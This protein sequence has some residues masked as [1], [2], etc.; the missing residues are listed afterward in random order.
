MFLPMYLAKS[1]MVPLKCPNC[2]STEPTSLDNSSLVLPIVAAT[3]DIALSKLAPVFAAV[4]ANP[5][6]A[7]PAAANPIFAAR[8]TL[9]S[10]P[11]TPLPKL[12][13]A[14]FAFARPRSNWDESIVSIAAISNPFILVFL[15]VFGKPGTDS[16]LYFFCARCFLV[17]LQQISEPCFNTVASKRFSLVIDKKA[18]TVGHIYPIC[19]HLVLSPEPCRTISKERPYSSA[20]CVLSVA[21]PDESSVS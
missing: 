15:L 14:P 21:E 4:A 6:D 7:T 11:P 3:C 20:S 12:V 2:V 16:R 19:A 10:T 5:T 1:R 17:W 18:R 13:A 9:P 8:P